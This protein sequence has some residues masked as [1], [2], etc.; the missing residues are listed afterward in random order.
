MNLSF[1]QN[2]VSLCSFTPQNHITIQKVKLELSLKMALSKNWSL[3]VTETVIV[4][5]LNM[6]HCQ[7][8][9]EGRKYGDGNSFWLLTFK[10]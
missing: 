6:L 4:W 2:A 8:S 10:R 1:L 3:N 7:L 5:K 9:W